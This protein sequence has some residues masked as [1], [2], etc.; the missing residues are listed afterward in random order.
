MDERDW[1]IAELETAL[2]KIRSLPSEKNVEGCETLIREDVLRIAC[3][4]LDGGD[5]RRYLDRGECV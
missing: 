4:V 2:R 3:G 1:R 5:G